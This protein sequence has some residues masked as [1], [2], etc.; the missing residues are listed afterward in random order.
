MAHTGCAP[1]RLH[2]YDKRRAARNGTNCEYAAK[3]IL[4]RKTS[5]K[6]HTADDQ[7]QPKC[8]HVVPPN[9]QRRPATV[10]T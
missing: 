5:F 4:D 9:E 8:R 3:R 1:K 2:V 6:A 10:E 7:R